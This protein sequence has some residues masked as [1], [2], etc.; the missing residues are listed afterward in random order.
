MN[1]GEAK[2]TTIKKICQLNPIQ[3]AFNKAEMKR[4][5]VTTLGELLKE[6]GKNP[7]SFHNIKN[8]IPE[9]I[10]QLAN[11]YLDKCAHRN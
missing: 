6:N 7:N 3:A 5:K 4:L 9:S 1:L 11:Q 10:L 8:K 2:Q